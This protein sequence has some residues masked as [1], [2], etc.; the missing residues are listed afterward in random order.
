MVAAS[1][2]VPN[3]TANT[4]FCAATNAASPPQVPASRHPC[5]SAHS[6]EGTSSAAMS[7]AP[8][9][10][11]DRP[12]PWVSA[13]RNLAYASA[14]AAVSVKPR[15]GG[16]G[17]H[18]RQ[19]DAVAALVARPVQACRH[20]G[21]DRGVPRVQ[22]L[23]LRILGHGIAHGGGWKRG[24]V[25]APRLERPGADVAESHGRPAACSA[26]MSACAVSTDRPRKPIRRATCRGF[27]PAEPARR[28]E[29]AGRHGVETDASV[30]TRVPRVSP[31]ATTAAA[32]AS[33]TVAAATR[34]PVRAAPIIRDRDSSRAAHRRKTEKTAVRV[35][36]FGHLPATEPA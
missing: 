17:R 10:P 27:P 16:A 26:S 24:S 33:A 6:K 19:I 14:S 12:R 1:A 34:P 7:S 11:A 28:L 4:T 8:P 13:A 22:P 3:S 9:R 30:V 32:A 29:T 35:T 36:T 25:A 20:H 2:A 21:S 31:Q 15:V 18:G 23:L 5:V